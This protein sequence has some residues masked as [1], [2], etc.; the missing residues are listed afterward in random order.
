MRRLDR[1]FPTRPD[2]TGPLT[3]HRTRRYNFLIRRHGNGAKRR[4]DE[5]RP[6]A[7]WGEPAP[8]EPERQRGRQACSPSAWL[9]IRL[10]TITIEAMMSS[11]VTPPS[12]HGE[13]MRLSSHMPAATSGIFPVSGK[14]LFSSL[15]RSESTAF[16]ESAALSGD[17]ACRAAWPRATGPFCFR[18]AAGTPRSSGFYPGKMI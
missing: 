7:S 14:D 2:L 17:F 4:W 15:P 10:S 16:S 12:P 3:P 5:R 1:D 18:A 9:R 11:D 13:T 8:D 6:R